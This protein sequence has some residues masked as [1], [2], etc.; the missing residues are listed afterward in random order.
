MFGALGLSLVFVGF[1]LVFNGI[2]ILQRLDRKSIIVVNLITAFLLFLI[3]TIS[4]VN[5]IGGSSD[6]SQYVSVAQ[7]YLF[8]FTYLFIA[9]NH[10]LKLDPRTFGWYCL[11]ATV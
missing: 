5:A 3:N 11:F 7:G 9:M 6:V 2:A 4:L 8:A 10:L 1:T